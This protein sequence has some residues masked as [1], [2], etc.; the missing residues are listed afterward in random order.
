MP[1]LQGP[2]AASRRLSRAVDVDL[3]KDT[4]CKNLYYDSLR[5]L[6]TSSLIKRAKSCNC[7]TI[8]CSILLRTYISE[9]EAYMFM[10][11]CMLILCIHT[12]IIL[13]TSYIHFDTVKNSVPVSLLIYKILA[14][15]KLNLQVY[16]FNINNIIYI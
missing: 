2:R 14:I 12:L 8:L 10:Y 7:S 5:C 6:S 13:Y 16:I 4:F 11:V 9:I 1:N 15:L 3:F